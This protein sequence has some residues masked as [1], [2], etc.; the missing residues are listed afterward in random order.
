MQACRFPEPA[1]PRE[2][3]TQANIADRAGHLWEEGYTY[4]AR[5]GIVTSPKGDRYRVD[6][7]ADTCSCEA[8]KRHGDCKHRMAVARLQAKQRPAARPQAEAA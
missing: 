8:I 1:N 5:T 3:L 4:D 2:A 7:M 6:T